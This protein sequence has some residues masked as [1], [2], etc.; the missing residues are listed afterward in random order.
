MKKYILP[1]I[2]LLTTLLLIISILKLNMIP[3][4]YLLIIV[5]IEAILLLIGTI[6]NINKN[7]ILKIIGIIL[8]ITTIIINSIG[9]YYINHTNKFIKQNF[10]NNIIEMNKYNVI[11]L[12]ES[13]YNN[14]EEIKSEIGYLKQDINYKEQLN[15]ELKEY[16]S[17]YEL[18]EDLLNKKI[19]SI[20]LEDTYIELLKD[21]YKDIE[22]KIK[23]IYSFDITNEIKKQEETTELNS[24]NIYISG[25]DSRSGRIESKTRTDVNMIVTINSNTNKI[26][27][28]S[29]PRDYYVQLHGTT[30]YKDKLTHSGIYGIE[31]SKTTLEDLFSIKIDYVI[32]VGFNSV[33]EI[34]DLIDGIEIE[35]D[36]TFTTRCGDGGAQKTQVV[37]GINHFNGAQALSYARERYAYIE[38]DNHRIQNQQQVLEAIIEKISKNKSLIVKY[39]E[40]LDKISKLYKTDIPES[41]I[42]LYI[43]NQ[44]ENNTKWQIEKQVVTGTG[45]MDI[46]YSMP[47]RN[48]YVMIPNIESIEQASKKIKKNYQIKQKYQ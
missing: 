12:K 37:Q 5:L 32:K 25:S 9:L 27:L 36:K 11:V 22:E 39:N 46:T 38:G 33:V 4:K 23:I 6:L 34:V 7:K 21:D 19:E 29:I 45:S 17:I 42:K 41:L 1:I 30:G 26:L 2:T 43:K 28:T 48:L 35:S 44:I 16:N 20:I 3:N 15:K 14:I 13:K 47:G 10:N 18:Y 40:L 31:M 24:I 8:L